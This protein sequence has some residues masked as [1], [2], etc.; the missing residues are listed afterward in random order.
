MTIVERAKM[1]IALLKKKPKPIKPT[2]PR[3]EIR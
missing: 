3:P 2:K 1:I